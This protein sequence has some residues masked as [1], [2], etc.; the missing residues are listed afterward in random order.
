[1]KEQGYQDSYTQYSQVHRR[2]HQ[3]LAAIM[4]D[5]KLMELRRT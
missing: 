3:E 4:N 1:M 2:Q 5:A